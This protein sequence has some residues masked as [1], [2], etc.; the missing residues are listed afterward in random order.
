M[1][2]IPLMLGANVSPLLAVVQGAGFALRM[3]A[4]PFSRE[5]SRSQPLRREIDREVFVHVSQLAQ[6]AACA[7]FHMVEER[8]ACW[9]LMTEDC[10]HSGTF[11]ITQQFLSL[12]LGVR[13]VGITAAAGSLQE[14]KL[15]GYSRGNIAILDRLGLKAASCSCYKANREL[16]QRAFT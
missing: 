15:I 1:L 2:G 4:L 6:K 3:D 7:R 11:Y 8:L 13:R 16:S 5:L 9:L 10:G 14:R 12:M